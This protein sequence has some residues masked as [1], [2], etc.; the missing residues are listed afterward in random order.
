MVQKIVLAASVFASGVFAADNAVVVHGKVV[1]DDL[2]GFKLLRPGQ[3]GYDAA[4]S[5]AWGSYNNS[6]NVT[7]WGLLDIH[8][9]AS[10]S[11]SDIAAA[12]GYLE[13]ALMSAVPADDGKSMLNIIWDH[14]QVLN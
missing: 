8:G 10:Y 1:K 5:I 2:S 3:D 12:A 7:G 13:G 14:V 9:N 11:D 6:I 4:P